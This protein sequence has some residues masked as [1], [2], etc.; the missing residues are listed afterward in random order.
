MFAQARE[1]AG[2]GETSID[3]STVG[4]VLDGAATRFGPRFAAVLGASAVWLN[5]EPAERANPVSDRDEVAVLPPVS[6]G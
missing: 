4:D 5:G 2:T 3:G 6:G 1:S